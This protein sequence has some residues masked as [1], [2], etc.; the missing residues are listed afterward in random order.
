[1]NNFFQ[2]LR[3]ALRQLRKR[4]GFTAVAVVTLALGIAATTVLYSIL[5]GAY[6][7]FAPTEQGN[8]NTLIIQHFT[9]QG[10]QTARFSA[11]EYLDFVNFH[12]PFE[13]F[14]A[15]RHS[16]AAL[17][18]E[19]EQ[20]TNP[21][22][23]PIVHATANIFSLNGIAPIAGHVFT[24]E[25]DHP[26]G[27]N[28]AVLTYRLWARRFN[29]NAGIV[30]KIVRLDGIP[31]TVIGITPRR[32]QTWGADIYLPLRL[33]SASIDRSVRDL[34]VSG[35]RKAGISAEQTA[36]F[37]QQVAER[38]ETRYES[39][40]HEYA[41]LVY[42]PID[43]RV[44]VMSDLRIA[45]YLLMGAVALLLLIA[46]ANLANLLVA[47]TLARAREIAT[48]LAIGATT[49]RLSRQFLTE[50]TILAFVA[51][52]LGV[53]L[54]VVALR[55]TLSLIPA[56]YI[57]EESEIHISFP[58]LAISFSLA[59]VL[60]LLFGSVPMVF[61]S[62]RGILRNLGQSRMVL[63]DSHRSRYR[64]A[65]LLPQIALAFVVLTSAGLMFRTYQQITSMDLG[66]DPAHVLTMRVALSTMRYSDSAAIVNFSRRLIE[67][68]RALP[69]V[70]DAAVSSRR[71]MEGGRPNLVDF[72]VPGRQLNTIQGVAHAECRIV[73]PSYFAV[74]RNRVREGR[75]FTDEDQPHAP[76]VAIV[77]ESFVRT[78]MPNDTAIGKQL[79]LLLTADA[80]GTGL[81]QIVGVVADSRQFAW[82]VRNVLYEPSS[83]EIFLP[84]VQHPQ[85]ARDLAVLLRSRAEPTSLTEAVRQQIQSLNSEQSVYDIQ[86]LQDMTDES[87]GPAHLCLVL[88]AALA[89]TALITACIGLYAIVSYGVAQRTQEI[90]VRMAIGAERRDIARLVISEGMR[91][92]L[93][94]VAA[95]LA[96]SFGTAR[97]MSGLLYRVPPHD[98]ATLIS[99]CIIL[100]LVS[101]L[102]TYFPA[103][104]AAK[105]D[106]IVALRYE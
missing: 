65:M 10:S 3:Y 22:Q 20:G 69:G 6:L 38:E 86:T 13:G 56:H 50:S 77:N 33:D 80:P 29:R 32:F 51:A 8:R 62:R 73:T 90:G 67:Q 26:G 55:P 97:L 105:V 76:A 89:T 47:R 68:V 36:P 34:T 23:V 98:L 15:I 35:V 11:A 85:S 60:G 58:A 45:V 70:I 103:R 75:A 16:G 92:V 61:V 17:T 100:T 27:P 106:P 71:P 40:N 74:I 28:V 9:K 4:P 30:G 99:V 78:Y 96:V 31:Y 46:S 84:L 2:D 49:S 37:L 54:G 87:L 48:R 79:R 7:H 25:D 66:F 88:L 19:T 57:G 91:L 83:P 53:F 44:A 81:V 41:G 59:V 82:D 5:D 24:Q 43:I 95:G 64:V 93:V 39:T 52:L 63:A 72:S 42:E 104:R 18:E 21:E 12:G 102:A 94:G 14:L 101:A 1:M